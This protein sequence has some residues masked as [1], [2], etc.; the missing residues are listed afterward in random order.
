[1]NVCIR[2]NCVVVVCVAIDAWSARDIVLMRDTDFLLTAW[3]PLSCMS[4]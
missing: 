3:R 1:M 2:E 4:L